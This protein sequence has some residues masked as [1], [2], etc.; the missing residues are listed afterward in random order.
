MARPA[1]VRMRNRKPWVFARRRLF[2]WNVRLLTRGLQEEG[3]VRPLCHRGRKLCGPQVRRNSYGT[4]PPPTRSNLVPPP[5]G[6]WCH[7]LKTTGPTLKEQEFH[8]VHNTFVTQDT[9]C[10][11]RLEAQGGTLLASHGPDLVEVDRRSSDMMQCTERRQCCVHRL[12]TT[13]WTNDLLTTT[14]NRNRAQ[15][16]RETARRGRPERGARVRPIRERH[17]GNRR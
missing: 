5:K 14:N 4:G 7:P 12:W 6:N 10:G 11:E 15:I 3:S 2:G 16:H 8:P 1:R 17:A 9:A 13:V